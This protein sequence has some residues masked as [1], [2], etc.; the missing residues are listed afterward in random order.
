MTKL[1]LL[2]GLVTCSSAFAGM[3]LD[4]Q[5]CANYT[6]EKIADMPPVN[7]YP[8]TMHH[9]VFTICGLQNDVSYKIV[10]GSEF[11]MEIATQN[12][13][14]IKDKGDRV[15]T[16]VNGCISGER[17]VALFSDSFVFPVRLMDL[18]D[19][20]ETIVEVASARSCH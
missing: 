19:G 6:S 2:V 10:K 15:V 18:R 14:S 9:Q 12:S 5:P 20:R 4:W 7:G 16:P 1:V 13:Y 11:V 17:T 8:A 3:D